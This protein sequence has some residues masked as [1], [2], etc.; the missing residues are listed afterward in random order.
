MRALNV[1]VIVLATLLSGTVA[2][3][4][5]R[6]AADVSCNPASGN[7]VYRCNIVLTGRDSGNPVE[8]A[9]VIVKFSMPSMPMAHNVPPVKAEPGSMPGHFTATF[10]LEMTGEWALTL[11]V[12]GPVRDRL[13]RKVNF[14]SS[15]SMRDRE[16]G[17]H[18]DR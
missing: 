13:I 2:Y 17:R 18:K 15:K 4:A 7:L 14:G 16:H 5:E 8:N 12:S 9:G 1:H 6:V 11:D 10:E 3:S